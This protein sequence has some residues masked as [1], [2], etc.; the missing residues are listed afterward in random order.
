MFWSDLIRFDQ[1]WIFCFFLK[2]FDFFLKSWILFIIFFG[3]HWFQPKKKRWPEA[4]GKGLFC[5]KTEIEIN[6]HVN[7]M[8]C[9]LFFFW[10]HFSNSCSLFVQNI[11]IRNQ[12]KH[13]LILCV[14]CVLKYMFAL[15]QRHIIFVIQTSK[16]S[17]YVF[18]YIKKLFFSSL[19]LHVL[20]FFK[21]M[22]LY[23]SIYIYTYMFSIFIF[24]NIF[25]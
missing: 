8:D 16:H 23:L 18:L 15:F 14:C 9:F 20:Y 17:K 19:N 5:F 2:F 25:I 1:I 11:S 12:E 10:W 3:F 4:F 6:S 24:L 22:Y 21:F 13:I 7:E